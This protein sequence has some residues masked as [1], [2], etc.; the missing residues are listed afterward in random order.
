MNREED[1]VIEKVV[2]NGKTYVEINDYEKLRTLFGQLLR[3]VQR[4]KSQGDYEAGKNLIETYGVKVDQEM[5]KEVHQRYESLD[6]APYSGF[7]NPK[8]IPVMDGDKIVDIKVE[9]PMIFWNKCWNM[10]EIILFWN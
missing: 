8:L 9:Q 5:L 2:K 6:V 4:I 1:N 7:I 3:E 10:E